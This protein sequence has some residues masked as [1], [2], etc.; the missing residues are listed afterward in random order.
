MNSAML[1]PW[2]PAMG[3]LQELMV[4]LLQLL[5]IWLANV[6]GLPLRP[7]TSQEMVP[8]SVLGHTYVGYSLFVLRFFVDVAELQKE[9]VVLGI[10]VSEKKSL[11]LVA[12][13]HSVLPELTSESVL[14][15]LSSLH[16]DILR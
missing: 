13:Y 6:L 9:F 3:R 2:C 4:E 14:L 10:L 1:P 11:D 8:S 16:F 15:S 12:S 5:G 7:P